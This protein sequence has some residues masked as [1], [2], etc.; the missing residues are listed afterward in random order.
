MILLDISRQVRWVVAAMPNLEIPEL[1]PRS[2]SSSVAF[3]RVLL[4]VLAAATGAVGCGSD[5]APTTPS[6]PAAVSV[7]ETFSDTVTVNGA[8]TTPFTANR[9]GTVT[10]KLTA[11]SPDDTIT[12]GLSIGTWNGAACALSITNDAAKLNATVVG[13]AQATGQ[14]CA[15]VYDVGLLTAATNYTLEITHF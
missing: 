11:L 2:T 14:F 8:K 15:R 9:A 12:L 3:S 4:I 1:M 7:T 10:A 13:T 5:N 6:E